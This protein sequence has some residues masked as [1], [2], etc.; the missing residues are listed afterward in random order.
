MAGLRINVMWWYRARTRENKK[1]YVEYDKV[2]QLKTPLKRCFKRLNNSTL[3]KVNG[4]RY[5][6]FTLESRVTPL[7]NFHPYSWSDSYLTH[8]R[9]NIQSLY[10]FSQC[11]THWCNRIFD[12][13]ISQDLLKTPIKS[14]IYRNVLYLVFHK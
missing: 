11:L 7:T 4:I 10:L 2:E 6:R 8:Q 13:M 12:W 9:I 5:C 1:R 3:K 14:I